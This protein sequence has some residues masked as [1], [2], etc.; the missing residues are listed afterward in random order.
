MAR[1]L[2]EIQD[3]TIRP[4]EPV[5][6]SG[7]LW[8]WFAREVIGPIDPADP[9]NARV[10]QAIVGIAN[11]GNDPRSLKRLIP[12]D[13]VHLPDHYK[14]CNVVVR[15]Q[16]GKLA[17]DHEGARAQIRYYEVPINLVAAVEALLPGS[18][19]WETAFLWTLAGPKVLS[20][21]VIRRHIA[22][23]IQILD[24][25]RPSVPERRQYL[26]PEAFDAFSSAS[27]SERKERYRVSLRPLSE[28]VSAHSMSLLAALCVESFLAEN[29]ILL[30]IHRQA[31]VEA[32]R[33]FFSNQI[34]KDARDTFIKLVGLKILDAYWD[35]PDLPVRSMLS[36]PL[37]PMGDWQS[38]TGHSWI[39]LPD[40]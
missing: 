24:L 2:A 25:C 34:M 31:L 16:S 38:Q 11:E 36:A 33:S 13:Q 27:L 26:S 9:F 17:N 14:Q 1:Y 20:L 35:E 8:A 4:R 30:D 18:A 29:E 22:H 3:G 32:M 40:L 37:V 12:I 23:L 10:G 39:Y 5:P 19:A 21:E 7:K 28:S 6:A 15:R